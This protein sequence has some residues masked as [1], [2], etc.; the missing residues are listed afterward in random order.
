ME[1]KSKLTQFIPGNLILRDY[2]K[3]V[4]HLAELVC[5]I[6]GWGGD[7]GDNPEPIEEVD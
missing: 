6:R 3:S 2:L 4:L 7:S 5:Y 1:L